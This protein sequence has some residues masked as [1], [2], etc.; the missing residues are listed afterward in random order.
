MLSKFFLNLIIFTLIITFIPKNSNANIYELSC[1][2]NKNTTTW[3]YSNKRKQVILTK[4]NNSKTKKNFQMGRQTP[5]SFSSKGDM[6]GLQ[7]NVTYNKNSNELAILQK[8]LRGS[9]EFYKC[10][11]PKLLKEE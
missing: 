7:T 6:R 5:S 3:V 4:V 2:N 11:E 10:S 9:N 8:S 1:K